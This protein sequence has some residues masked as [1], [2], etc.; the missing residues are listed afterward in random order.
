[1]LI[2]GHVYLVTVRKSGT[3]STSTVHKGLLQESHGTE[4]TEA[5]RRDHI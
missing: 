5:E 1:M 3:V 4:P 2:M